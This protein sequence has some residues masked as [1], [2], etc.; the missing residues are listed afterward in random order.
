MPSGYYCE[1]NY[2]CQLPTPDVNTEIVLRDFAAA[3]YIFTAK[4]HLSG[5]PNNNIPSQWSF[6]EEFVAPTAA[7][8]P[9]DAQ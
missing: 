1:A 2:T 9:N 3:P 7:P 4:P 8:S 6:K 5:D